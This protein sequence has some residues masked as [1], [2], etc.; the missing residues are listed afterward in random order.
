MKIRKLKLDNEFLLEKI[1][2]CF[3]TLYHKKMHYTKSLQY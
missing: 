3:Y 1:V 2:T